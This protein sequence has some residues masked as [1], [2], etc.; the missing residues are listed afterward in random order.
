MTRVW[1]ITWLLSAAPLSSHHLV[2]AHAS[3]TIRACDCVLCFRNCSTKKRFL[4]WHMEKKN[5]FQ[6]RTKILQEENSNCDILFVS[7][8]FLC[9]VFISN[10]CRLSLYF[11][12]D[13]IRQWG[14]ETSSNMGN[15]E[16]HLYR[17]CSSGSLSGLVRQ[18]SQQ[19]WNRSTASTHRYTPIHTIRAVKHGSQRPVSFGNIEV[20][21]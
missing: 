6:W 19:F 21:P 10:N 13:S 14:T 18:Q 12:T 8:T 1:Q 9:P 17:W 20:M 15:G 7:L 16:S 5:I 4:F 2:L 11:K 3:G